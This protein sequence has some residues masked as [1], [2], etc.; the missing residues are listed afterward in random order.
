MNCDFEMNEIL[1]MYIWKL[2]QYIDGWIE[3]GSCWMNIK[4][5]NG[6]CIGF[7]MEMEIGLKDG[8]WNLDWNVVIL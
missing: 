7:K 1:L 4:M 3:I 2:N 6:L 8:L 5:V